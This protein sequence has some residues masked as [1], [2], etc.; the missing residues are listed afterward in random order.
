VQIWDVR[1]WRTPVTLEGHTRE[2][3]DID[4]SSDGSRIASSST[5]GTVR[6]W[7]CNTGSLLGIMADED[8][9]PVWST[10]WTQRNRA[11]IAGG[12]RI[13]LWK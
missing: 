13:L 7:D 9:S 3:T 8:A 12:E 2:I 5:D 10:R 4:F 6:L 1:R 11:I